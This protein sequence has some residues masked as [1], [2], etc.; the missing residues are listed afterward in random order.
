M[1]KNGYTPPTAN[2]GLHMTWG[3]AYWVSLEMC[4]GSLLPELEALARLANIA[5]LLLTK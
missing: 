1:P 5:F 2:K 3:L 4:L